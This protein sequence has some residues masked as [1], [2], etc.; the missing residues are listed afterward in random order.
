MRYPVGPVFIVR[1][2]GFYLVPPPKFES[3]YPKVRTQHGMRLRLVPVPPG[4]DD[5]GGAACFV[6]VENPDGHVEAPVLSVA[7]LWLENPENAEI[8]NPPNETSKRRVA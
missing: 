4:E 7:R 3:Q 2:E 8:V 1:T 5:L 6:R